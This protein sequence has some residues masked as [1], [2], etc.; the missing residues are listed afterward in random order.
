MVINRAEHRIRAAGN[1]R[2]LAHP[3]H[4]PERLCKLKLPLCFAIAFALWNGY[5][6]CVS[7]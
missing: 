2:P 5:N 6:G 3:T 1:A 7:G 4:V